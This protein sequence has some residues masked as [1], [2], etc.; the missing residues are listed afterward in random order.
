MSLAPSQS[1]FDIAALP[2]TSINQSAHRTDAI[3]ARDYQREMMDGGKRGIGVRAAL[4]IARATLVQSATGTG[5]GPMLA[6]VA[7]MFAGKVMILQHRKELITQNQKHVRVICG[8]H[9]TIEKATFTASAHS[10]VVVG[11]MQTQITTSKKTGSARMSKFD[12]MEFDALIIDEAHRAASKGYRKII[13]YYM[14]GN[15]NLKLIGFTA[16]PD[17]HDGQALKDLFGEMCFRFPI[18]EAIEEGWLCPIHA[19]PVRVADLDLSRVRTKRGDFNESDLAAVMEFEKV[20]HELATPTIEISCGLSRGF[21]QELLDQ[22]KDDLSLASMALTKR[23][24]LCRRR[25][26][27]IFCAS[28]VHAERLCEI[29][30]RWIPDSAAFVC[31][32]KK[33]CSD[34]DRD[35]RIRDFGARRRQYMCNV[36]VFTE[37][38]DIPGVEIIVMGKP[39]KSRPKFEQMAGRGTRPHESL[40]RRIGELV[41]PAQ[42]RQLIADSPKPFCE[43]LDLVGNTGKHKLIT[44]TDLLGG[45]YSEKA[46]EVARKKIK[47]QAENNAIPGDV[48]QLLKLAQDELDEADKQKRIAEEKEKAAR[49][50]IRATAVYD[51]SEVNLFD[52]YDI[53]P[54]RERWYTQ[55]PASPKQIEALRRKGFD[56]DPER[57]SC[58]EAGKLLSQLRGRATQN[59]IKCL[60]GRNKYSLDEVRNLTIEQASR[61]IDKV[62]A[63]G[64]RRPIGDVQ[65]NTA[66][67]PV[68]EPF[69]FEMEV[70][71]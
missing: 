69:P 31:G 30:N 23:L 50:G 18:N 17:R 42:R 56:F 28:I 58:G 41:D 57:I 70:I 62:K 15:P 29:L 59:Q 55:P 65:A 37:G 38:T 26:T 44:V 51:I 67:P 13:R 45:N 5:K 34:D 40:A 4:S 27:I 54:P 49:Q 3:V 19:H 48:I 2:A 47:E 52:V 32:D 63:N 20:L 36:D 8:E 61:L 24:E 43:I 7:G 25:Q 35:D 21:L 46:K 68:A 1:L 64:W 60:V 12:P 6:M 10:R 33:K 66:V 14:D 53:K 22:H 9:A 11:S 39:T 71:Q 16:T